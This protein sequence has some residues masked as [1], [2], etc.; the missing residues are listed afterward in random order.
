MRLAELGEP[1]DDLIAREIEARIKKAKR[2]VVLGHERPD[3]DCLGSTIA[4]GATLLDQGY[5][6]HVLLETSLP[7]RFHFLFDHPVLKRRAKIETRR[8]YP[9]D[10]AIVLDTTDVDRLS[11]V[12]PAQIAGATVINIDHHVSNNNFG[13][14]NWVDHKA[15]AA[16]E[17][18]WRLAS[19]LGWP[20]PRIALE[21]LYVALVTDTGQF[22]Y[23]N[24]TPR[25]LRMAAALVE[26]GVDPEDLWRRIYLNKSLAELDLEARAR[27]SMEVWRKG[28]ICAITLTQS[29]FEKTHCGPETTQEFPGIPRALAGA[30]LALFFYAVEGGKQTKISIRSVREIDACALAKRFG[31][32]GHRQAAGCRIP[33]PVKE[34]KELFR[35][36]AEKAVNGR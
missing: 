17:L 29:D 31:G 2:I 6:A 35:P 10:L 20:V 36:A 32:G 26:Y 28:R 14:V 24:T 5:D 34:A 22:A 21:A 12:V 33:L 27:T 1:K 23:S 16:G 9:A 13:D 19:C 3:G 4:L 7:E 15:S 11:A 18:V 30:K 25:V 8:R